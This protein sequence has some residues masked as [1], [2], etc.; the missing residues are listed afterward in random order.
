MLHSIIL[1]KHHLYTTLP[2]LITFCIGIY[3]SFS[4]QKS[5]YINSAISAG[6]YLLKNIDEEGKYTYEYNPLTK[7]VSNHY[8]IL[9]HAGTT[10]S[11]LELYQLT[12]DQR[13]L[14]SSEQA[15][16]YL[17]R[18]TQECVKIPDANC[19]VED[20]ETKLGGNGLAILAV[21]KYTEVTG[22]SE[23][24]EYAQSLAQFITQTQSEAGQFTHHMVSSSTGEILPFESS[25]YPGEAIFA[26]TRLYEQDKDNKW[27][28]AA[29]KGAMWL[30]EVRDKDK[31]IYTI[32]H[33]HWL[34]YALNELHKDNRNPIY[35]EHTK[36]IVDG[37][38]LKQN[39]GYNGSQKVWNGGYY[40]PPTS[41]ATAT[42]N[43]G[44]TA[45]YQI[46]KR[47]KEKEYMKKTLDT[48]QRGLHFQ[49]ANQ[50]TQDDVNTLNINPNSIG[51]FYHSLD[52]YD[53]RIDYVQHNISAI[54]GYINI[55]NSK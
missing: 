49:I 21:S 22:D 41:T 52:N 1:M 15:I 38:I 13:L 4:N 47:E 51:A 30:I 33:D 12:G 31:D 43:E 16:G 11:L 34:L 25:Y 55:L 28:E 3:I 32:Q 45:A 17:I 2:L 14:K 23:Y 19:L 44:L 37:I 40:I 39:I 48:I 36:K 29:H 35:L 26:L 27:I 9:R 5:I 18:N 7:K 46:F 54:L 8:N 24:L 10:Y 50:I 20:E 42:R 6:E 53:I